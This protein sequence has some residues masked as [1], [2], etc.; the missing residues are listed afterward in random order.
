M[1]KI[2]KFFKQ[3]ELQLKMI[4][5]FILMG[6]IVFFVAFLGWQVTLNLSQ[7]LNEIS[8]VRLPSIL[9]LAK[10]D[11]KNNKKFL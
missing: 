5:A 6:L 9:G 3:G 1:K 8:V 2:I 4:N 10:I 11:G 7:E